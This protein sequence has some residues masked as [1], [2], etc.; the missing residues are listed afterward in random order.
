[1]RISSSH[2]SLGSS[3]PNPKSVHFTKLKELNIKTAD[4]M[5]TA[6]ELEET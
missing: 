5:P 3:G 1:M 2:P 4:S 6:S